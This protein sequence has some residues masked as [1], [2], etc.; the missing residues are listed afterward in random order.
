MIRSGMLR[1]ARYQAGD[2]LLQKASVP[3]VL[4]LFIGGMTVYMSSRGLVPLDWSTEMGA[5]SARAVLKQASDLFFPLAAFLGVNA[6]S[7]ADRQHGHVRFVFSKPVV[8]PFYYLQQWAVYGAALVLLGGA[9]AVLLQLFTTTIPVVG[10]MEAA[11]LTWILVGGIGYLCS[12][13]TRFDGALLILGWVVSNILRSLASMQPESPL[14]SW[15]LPIVKALPPVDR[16][17]TARS[18]LYAGQSIGSGSVLHVV[19]YGLACL[20]L[21][22]LILRRRSLIT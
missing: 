4:A 15:L 16:L 1:Y 2:F 10:A 7:S 18:A 22:T 17:D 8:V 3:A 11:A 21:G 5:A 9:L 6:I 19:G 20:A 13:V 14:P 12:S